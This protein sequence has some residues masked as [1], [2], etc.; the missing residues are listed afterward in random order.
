MTG[1][2]A[3][4]LTFSSAMAVLWFGSSILFGVATYYLGT[5]GTILGWPMFMASIVISAS[6][7]GWLAGEWK[8]A[9]RRPLFTQ[10]AG[11]SVLTLAI[12]LLSRV[13]T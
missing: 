8:T 13:R 7:F 5:L 2:T 4:Y 9:S 10:W 1:D 11:I 6:I 3:S 12:I